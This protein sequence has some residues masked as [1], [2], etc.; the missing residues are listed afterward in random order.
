MQHLP[1]TQLWARGIFPKFSCAQVSSEHLSPKHQH[2]IHPRFLTLEQ[3]TWG[4]EGLTLASTVLRA[5]G[6]SWPQSLMTLARCW[7]H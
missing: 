3:K 4:E 2:H 7:N 5:I 6:E 1:E